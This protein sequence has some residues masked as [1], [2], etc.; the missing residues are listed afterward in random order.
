MR[1]LR[2]P[3]IE[4]WLARAD[5]ERIDATDADSW[6]GSR[7]ALPSPPPVAPVTLAADDAPREGS[8]LRADP[9]HLRIAPEAISLHDASMLDVSPAEAHALVAV[10]QAHF[11]SDGFEFA[12]PS[13]S[14]WYVR[15]PEAEMPQTTPLDAAVGRNV[16]GLLPRGTG[17]VNWPSAITETQMLFSEHAVNVERE[18]DGRAPINSVWFWGG[19]SLP[20]ISERPYAIVYGDH[21]FARGLAKLAGTRAAETPAGFPQLDAVRENESVLLVLTALTDALRR[22]DEAEWIDAARTFDE[23]WFANM[24]DALARFDRV[25]IVMTSRMGSKVATLTPG[26]RWRVF[27][28]RKPVNADA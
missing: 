27:R 3:N 2:L 24:A 17:R 1:Q 12:A 15:V 7:F 6:I 8:W 14:R 22:G 21:A 28:S 5:V 13:P 23:R 19:G 20:A 4:R 25:R 11:A 18:A 9:V 16:F 26:S 10:L